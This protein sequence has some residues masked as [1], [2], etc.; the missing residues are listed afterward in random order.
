MTAPAAEDGAAA[1][2][3]G[4]QAGATGGGGRAGLPRVAPHP[5]LVGRL[6]GGDHGDE[7]CGWVLHHADQARV[8]TVE[9]RV[10]GKALA[11]VRANQARPDLAALRLRTGCGFRM[12]VPASV[13]DG[14]IRTLE[15]WV[16]PEGVRLGQRRPI[17]GVIR[18]H[19]PYPKEFSADSILRLEDGPIDYDRV[20]HS[21]FLARH[22]VRA[23]VAYA[24][25][26]LLKRPPDRSGWDHYSE[27][28]LAG[29]M[30]LGEVLRG[31][32][33]SDEAAKARR[34][35][36]DLL[37]DFEAALNAAAGLP[38]PPVE[39]GSS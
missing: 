28:I 29:E 37:I 13:F 19:K 1:A 25:L 12:T 26:W 32:A 14:V 23:A 3:S 33:Q 2:A 10:D 5:T 11:Q 36:L 15:V 18:D 24:Y 16:Q 39:G 21:A 34:S 38:E 35:G 30:G 7:V 8:C 22:G 31:L 20:F 27:K 17:T 9:L 4:G 6:D